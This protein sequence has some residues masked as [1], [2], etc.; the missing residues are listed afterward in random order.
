MKQSPYEKPGERDD[1]P[2]SGKDQM[3][4]SASDN[5]VILSFFDMFPYQGR[6]QSKKKKSVEN[7]TLGS[8]PDLAVT[9]SDL[10]LKS[11]SIPPYKMT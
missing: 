6:V 8:D 10:K 7:S 4:A 2:T 11:I 5:N 9:H 3:K 1:D